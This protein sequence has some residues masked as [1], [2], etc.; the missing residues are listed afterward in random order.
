MAESD[1]GFVTVDNRQGSYNAVCTEC[2]WRSGPVHKPSA[3][4]ATF[5]R[6]ECDPDEHGGGV[7]IRQDPDAKVVES[8]DLGRLGTLTTAP[9]GPPPGG[10]PGPEAEALEVERAAPVTEPER[11]QPLTEPDRASPVAEKR[12]EG[13]PIDETAEAE[14]SA[15]EAE[16][17]DGYSVEERGG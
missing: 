9:A 8:A 5:S 13:T 17:P 2:G 10:A 15:G 16:L 6:H 1:D 4:R 12:A 3:A 11:E 14:E 7:E